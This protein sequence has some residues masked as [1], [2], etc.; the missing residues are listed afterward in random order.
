MIRGGIGALILVA[1]ILM[2]SAYCLNDGLAQQNIRAA[3]GRIYAIDTFKS[4]ITVR[5]LLFDPV[6]VYKNVTLFVGPNTK[7]MRLGSA[8]SIFDLTMGSPVN[9]KYADNGDTPEA[10][11]ITVTK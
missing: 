7:M 3:E 5:S 4:T 10:L 11:S 6:I 9:V 8:I 1:V 2:S